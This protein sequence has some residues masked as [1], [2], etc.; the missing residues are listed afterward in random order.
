[1][2]QRDI[3]KKLGVS[4]ATVSRALRTDPKTAPETI[5]KIKDAAE[6]MGYRPDP[7]FQVLIERRW[8]GRRSNDGLN[9]SYVFDSKDLT[10]T[11]E[12]EYKRY[13]EAALTLGY[14]LIPE[15]LRDYP[16]IQKLMQRMDAKG[17]SGAVL[18]YISEAPYD[19]A[20]LLKNFAAVSINVSATQPDC[21][22]VMH[23]EFMA[24]EQ[25]WRRLKRDGYQRIGVLLEDY[26]ESFTMNQ[27]LGAVLCRHHRENNPD[28][29]IPIQFCN[30]RNHTQHTSVGEWVER[31]RP[32]VVVGDTH[33]HYET[34][35]L[36][37]YTM[38][39]DFAY[40]TINMWDPNYA[41][42]IAGY[43]RD[44]VILLRRSLQLLN[45]M[46]RSSSHGS[47][48]SDLIEMVNGEWLD[49]ESL[50]TLNQ[51]LSLRS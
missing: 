6:K 44:N 12:L 30:F 21:P 46:I 28:K 23:D 5:K 35:A 33:H 26:P 40:L 10:E 14:T 48:Q 20:D 27:R 19:I 2:T 49:G 47:D 25:I 16:S 11:D 13:R 43:F 3:A 4:V 1:M 50:P 32:D 34:L 41:G 24:I 18:S 15:D 29:L 45:L 8:R 17:V 36:L 42:Q 9:I 37:G 51:S 22:I 38:P 31:Y 7:G 39:K